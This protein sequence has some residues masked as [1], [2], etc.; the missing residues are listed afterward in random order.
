V[1]R[2]SDL[3]FP[4][5]PTERYW[6]D[7]ARGGHALRMEHFW[8]STLRVRVHGIRL[9]EF[10]APGG[11]PIWLP[12]YGVVDTFSRDRRTSDVPTLREEYHVM[13][14]SV[15]LNAGIP[16]ERF[17]TSWR[18]ETATSESLARVKAEYRRQLQNPPPRPSKTDPESVRQRL[19]LQLAEAD[20][21]A[22][23]LEASAPASLAAQSGQILRYALVVSGA[24]L[25][26]A[27][28]FLRRAS[29]AGTH[30]S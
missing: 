21:Q 25:I 5:K 23:A 9:A 16:D 4:T 24:I 12:V 3:S 6:I 28:V 29:Q 7:L 27:A 8:G 19:E 2:Y 15:R 22:K 18:A 30:R 13:R 10:K 20:R 11:L 17:S 26:A 14:S 1:D